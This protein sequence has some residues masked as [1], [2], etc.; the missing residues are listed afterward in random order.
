MPAIA[1]PISQEQRWSLTRL[2][3]AGQ[4]DASF[5]GDGKLQVSFPG[6]PRALHLAAG[7]ATVVHPCQIV[8]ARLTGGDHADH[9]EDFDPAGPPEPL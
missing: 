1:T 2:T 5:S 4:L 3:S 7:G 8:A 9:V 6:E